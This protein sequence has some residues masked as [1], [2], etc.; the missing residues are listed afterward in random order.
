MHFL[1]NFKNTPQ[2]LY[3]VFWSLVLYLNL[4]NGIQI[5]L[6]CL[7]NHPTDLKTM[8]Y[9]QKLKFHEHYKVVFLIPLNLFEEF[10]IMVTNT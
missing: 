3:Y 1:C 8:I 5:C 10:I 6:L 2:K 4:Q 9:V 7:L